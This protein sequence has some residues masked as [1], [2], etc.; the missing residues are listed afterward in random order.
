MYKRRR[1]TESSSVHGQPG[2]A[3]GALGLGSTLT[4]RHLF[5]EKESEAAHGLPHGVQS[6]AIQPIGY[7]MGNFGPVRR[8]ALK[9]FVY[10]DHWG[11][12]YQG[13]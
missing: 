5:H 10:L 6:Y 8:G 1:H 12:R 2:R 7:P 4:T 9:D 11:E 13:L 3:V